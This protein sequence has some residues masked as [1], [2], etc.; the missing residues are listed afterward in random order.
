VKGSGGDLSTLEPEGLAVL[1]LDRL[2]SMGRSTLVSVLVIVYFGSSGDGRDFN[3]AWT[4]RPSPKPTLKPSV[5]SSAVTELPWASTSQQG[6]ANALEIVN[7]AARYLEQHGR[8]APFGA[9]VLAN[10]PLPSN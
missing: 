6:E 9:D 2:R 3:L 8:P 7:V 4:S 5:A 10:Q 1:Q